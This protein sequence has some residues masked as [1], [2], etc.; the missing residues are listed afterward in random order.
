MSTDSTELTFV[1]CPSCR[2]L[3]PAVSTRCRMC[4]ASLD[5]TAGGDE[6]ERQK[7]SGRVRQRTMSGQK[8][9]MPPMQG[10]RREPAPEAAP[11]VEPEPDLEPEE[12]AQ[13]SDDP[14]S[15]YIEE[16]EDDDY[17]AGSE[18]ETEE[19]LE[20]EEPEP[21]ERTVVA[22]TLFTAP[23]QEE[24]FGAE[25][26][27]AEEMADEE[28]EE[29]LIADSYAAETESTI[30][31]VE[32]V[33]EEPEVSQPEP[34]EEAV[35]ETV[36]AEEEPAPQPRVI[37][38]SG[39]GRQRRSLFDR[40]QPAPQPR[41]RERRAAKHEAEEAAPAAPVQQ[42][43]KPVERPVEKP[44][45]EP[46][47]IVEEEAHEAAPEPESK[48]APR[49]E[50]RR[51]QPPVKPAPAKKG[52]LFGWFVSYS[53][54]GG[55]GIELRE[56]KF[57]ITRSSLKNSDLIID[58]ESISTPHAMVMVSVESGLRIHDLMS[59]RGVFLRKR[60]EDTYRREEDQ[61]AVQN[62]DWVRFGDV[63]F[64]V[65]LIPQVGVK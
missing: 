17:A 46:Q 5:A 1:R 30:E 54:P 41:E 47:E 18:E 2:S 32:E 43:R 64:L 28:K 16:V 53:E 4:G 50:V 20:E 29:E 7:T 40:P 63:E 38:E 27:S 34:D 37:I 51:G 8:E 39:R 44:V 62:G 10:L 19:E 59:E 52:R 14:L 11:A 61:L 6:E 21:L 25:A 58:H 49:A 24:E 31:A 60:G 3:V 12:E 13:E 33:E 56:G 48:P 9:Q 45:E 65:S 55:K 35:Q 42:A 23:K 36:E 15:A 22:K 26:E 57:F